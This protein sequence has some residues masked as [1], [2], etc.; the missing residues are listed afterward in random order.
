MIWRL[1]MWSSSIV[2]PFIVYCA[3]GIFSVGVAFLF[4]IS[5]VPLTIQIDGNTFCSIC[6]FFLNLHTT[7]V[8][9]LFI[10]I[11]GLKP[12]SGHFE[13]THTQELN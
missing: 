11:S 5:R 3:L 13:E 2:H 12:F 6:Y 1:N 10:I 9:N 7:R 4:G 8:P